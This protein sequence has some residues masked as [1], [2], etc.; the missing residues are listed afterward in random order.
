MGMHVDFR[1]I[2]LS[3]TAFELE[4]IVISGYKLE[5]YFRAMERQIRLDCVAF[6]FYK[7]RSKILRTIKLNAP[8]LILSVCKAQI[9]CSDF[10]NK[11][12]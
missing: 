8:F 4:I 2:K 5:S 12:L 10:Q 1:R 7:V 3:S 9:A 11:N 6:F